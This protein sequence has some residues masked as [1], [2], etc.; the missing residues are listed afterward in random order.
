MKHS[1]FRYSI[2]SMVSQLLIFQWRCILMTEEENTTLIFHFRFLKRMINFY[3]FV[4][5][6][7]CLMNY[8]VEV[9]SILWINSELQDLEIPFL[10][11]YSL[12]HVL[13]SV[14]AFCLKLYFFQNFF[15]QRRRCLI[16][17]Y[18]FLMCEDFYCTSELKFL[19]CY[20][21]IKYL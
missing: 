2:S 14:S 4:L 18:I 11:I 3:S 1:G 21:A 8:C 20:V 16:Q 9:I 13:N 5:L 15:E 12:R 6:L 17:I 10:L 7:S 19:R